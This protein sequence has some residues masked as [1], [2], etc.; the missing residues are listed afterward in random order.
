[1][2][3][4]TQCSDASA[5]KSATQAIILAF[6]LA[7]SEILKV[8]ERLSS[9][10][11]MPG[12][13]RAVE[14]TLTTFTLRESSREAKRLSSEEARDL[15]NALRKHVAGGI[16]EQIKAST[17][18]KN[19]EA[20]LKDLESALKCTPTGAWVDRHGRVLYVVGIGLVFGGAAALFIT[21]TDGKVVKAAEKVFRDKNF[22]IFKVGQFTLKGQVVQFEPHQRE[23]GV[24]LMATQQWEKLDLNSGLNLATGGP[25]VQGFHEQA[26]FKFGRL[27][28]GVSGEAAPQDKKVELGLQLGMS[29]RNR[30]RYFGANLMAITVENEKLKYQAELVFKMRY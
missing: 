13:Q 19:L 27:N 2:A 9:A 4:P 18:Y 6:D 3:G 28:L 24:K 7:R 21:R 8:P 25:L 16:Q 14:E 10:L 30:Q 17:A 12:V 23:L 29:S 1:M 20:A 26:I 5:G 22:R 11:R 15:L